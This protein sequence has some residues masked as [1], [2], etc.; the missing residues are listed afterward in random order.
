M[1]RLRCF[2]TAAS[3]RWRRPAFALLSLLLVGACSGGGK[4]DPEAQIM[5]QG[6]TFLYNA[7]DPAGAAAVFRVVLARNPAHYGAHYQL[8]IA[9]DQSGRPADA[10][11]AWEQVSRLARAIN[12]SATLA[13]ALARL[14]VPDTV[15]EA[16]IQA[17]M[18]T[19]G[20]NLMQRD[21]K[22]DLAAAAVQFTAVLE[23]NPTHY[24]ATYQ[25]ADALDRMGQHASARPLW[26]RTLEMARTNKDDRTIQLVLARLK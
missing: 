22:A 12:D 21:R 11:S 7:G 18:M 13:T 3:R 4:P 5:Q 25:L 10:R 16:V 2:R 14:A 15:S 17:G 1:K 9:L 19:V 23:R 20:M 8:A 24:G 6:L 26:E